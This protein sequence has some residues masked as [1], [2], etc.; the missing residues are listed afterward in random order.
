[1]VKE[2]IKHCHI[3]PP[4]F[5]VTKGKKYLLPNWI[6]VDDDL[7]LSDIEWTLPE[8]LIKKE[9]PLLKDDEWSVT[10]TKGRNTYSIKRV[11]NNY[12]CTCSGFGF[13]GKCKHVDQIKFQE[14]LK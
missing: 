8:F 4:A 7:Q 12:S 13:R 5:V 6:V 14:D 3:Y 11:N 2:K 10:S 1:M 9:I